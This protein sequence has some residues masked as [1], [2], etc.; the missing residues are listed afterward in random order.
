M[1]QA[2]AAVRSH[3]G[4]VP[5]A[6]DDQNRQNVGDS[7][8]L[9]GAVV[10]SEQ[11]IDACEGT[12]WLARN[13][14]H[15]ESLDSVEILRRVKHGLEEIRRRGAKPGERLGRIADEWTQHP[16]HLS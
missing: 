5:A 8:P 7:G 13:R 11:T 6:R 9:L 12:N 10:A 4:S 2:D 14:R 15:C 3:N 1:G 16:G